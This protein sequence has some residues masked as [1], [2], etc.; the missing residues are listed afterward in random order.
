MMFGQIVAEGGESVG[1][2]LE[3]GS[4][5]DDSLSIKN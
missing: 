1:G 5:E 4:D 2:R 3:P